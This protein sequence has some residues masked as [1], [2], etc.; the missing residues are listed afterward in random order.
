M[1]VVSVFIPSPSK[2]LHFYKKKLK[3]FKKG[4]EIILLEYD[5]VGLCFRN[6]I[7]QL[8]VLLI[9]YIEYMYIYK[10]ICI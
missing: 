1:L 10:Y 7:L 5:D 4:N 8:S 3:F 2:L 6:Q 9:E